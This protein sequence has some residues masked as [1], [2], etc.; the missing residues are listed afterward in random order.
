MTI[1][2]PLYP[3][4]WLLKADGVYWCPDINPES[5]YF[6]V[7]NENGRLV[8]YH[9]HESRAERKSYYA[10]ESARNPREGYVPVGIGCE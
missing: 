2:H 5:T 8:E 7:A 9:V 6:H 3:K 4:N 1:D 10:A